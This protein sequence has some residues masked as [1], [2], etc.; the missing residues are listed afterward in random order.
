[1]REIFR[2]LKPGGIVAI[3]FPQPRNPNAWLDP[4]HK[5]PYEVESWRFYCAGH[6]H[7]YYFDFAFEWA[8]VY[9]RTGYSGLKKR[10]VERFINVREWMGGFFNRH[11]WLLPYSFCEPVVFLRKPAVT[12]LD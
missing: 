5:R 12:T 1:M 6:H 2:V 8:G 7:N 11:M 10:W 3:A 9:Y 4:T